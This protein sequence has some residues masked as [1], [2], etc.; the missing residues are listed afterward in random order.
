M[1]EDRTMT[2]DRINPHQKAHA[3][4]LARQACARVFRDGGSPDDALDAFGLGGG[5]A[6]GFAG[7]FAG[8]G[9]TG[10]WSKAVDMIATA[11]CAQPNV[12]QRQAA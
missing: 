7:G 1:T 9:P 11:L 6:G 2:Q 5:L 10:D 8:Q 12:P 4:G 3:V